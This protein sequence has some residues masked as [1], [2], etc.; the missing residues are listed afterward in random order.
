MK[1]CNLIINST[2]FAFLYK[3]KLK[4]LKFY[5]VSLILNDNLKLRNPNLETIKFR[6]GLKSR[7]NILNFF[8]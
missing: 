4:K 1:L 8:Y 6:C 3:K 7:I 2:Y 5:I